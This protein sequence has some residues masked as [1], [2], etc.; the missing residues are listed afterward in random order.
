M[1][2]KDNK[3]VVPTIA[4]LILIKYTF[5]CGCPSWTTLPGW[6]VA[7]DFKI[8]GESQHKSPAKTQ[9]ILYVTIFN[10]TTVPAPLI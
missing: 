2:K 6:K 9:S 8:T 1:E 3:S 7:S 5:N 4:H 10:I